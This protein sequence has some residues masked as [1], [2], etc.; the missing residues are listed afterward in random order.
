[1]E[2]VGEILKS[3]RKKRRISLSTVV[4]DLKISMYILNKIENDEFDDN[5]EKVYLKGHIR[6]YAEYLGLDSREMI[7]KFQ[8]PVLI[9][10]VKSAVNFALKSKFPSSEE[11]YTDVYL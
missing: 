11:L 10:E 8:N 2:Y 5:I 3:K 7:N 9:E 4:K 6:T 1:M